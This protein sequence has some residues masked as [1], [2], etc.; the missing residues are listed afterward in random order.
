MI[1]EGN[2]VN[3][4]SLKKELSILTLKRIN[5]KLLIDVGESNSIVPFGSSAHMQLLEIF[6]KIYLS[7]KNQGLVKTYDIAYVVLNNYVMKNTSG[8]KISDLVTSDYL[9]PEKTEYANGKLY[10]FYIDEKSYNLGIYPIAENQMGEKI[11]YILN[12]YNKK[13]YAMTRIRLEHI[14]VDVDLKELFHDI[15]DIKGDVP[16]YIMENHFYNDR[17][18]LYLIKTYVNTAMKDFKTII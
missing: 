18:Y 15:E 7:A 8:F 1:A 16:E 6:T 5:N 17:N 2:P 12:S 9:I 11:Y 3:S 10:R 13:K 14:R 4:D